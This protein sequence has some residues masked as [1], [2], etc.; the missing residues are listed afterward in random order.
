MVEEWYLD[1]ILYLYPLMNAAVTKGFEFFQIN[2][3]VLT[4][5]FRNRK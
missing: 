5:I 4:K 1:T 3:L 2:T